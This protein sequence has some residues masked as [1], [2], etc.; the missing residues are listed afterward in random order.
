MITHPVV[1]LDSWAVTLTSMAAVEGWV[2]VA[3]PTPSNPSPDQF[4]TFHVSVESGVISISADTNCSCE[5][6][7]MSVPRI[8]QARGS[9]EVVGDRA[10]VWMAVWELILNRKITSP[11]EVV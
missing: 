3:Y 1:A 7:A 9:V 8:I 11:V 4:D 5:E 6:E 10:G 2:V